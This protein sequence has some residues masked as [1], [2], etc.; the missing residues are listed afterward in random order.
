MT[1]TIK[2]QSFLRRHGIKIGLIT[3]LIVAGLYHVATRHISD[4]TPFDFARHSQPIIE[5][6]NT[7]HYWLTND[8]DASPEF[9]LKYRASSASL[10]SMGK[11]HIYVLEKDHQFIGFVAYHLE[12]INEGRILY[13]AVKEEFR[14]KRYGQQLLEFGVQQLRALGAQKIRLT[15]RTDNISGQ[16]LYN[17]AGFKEVG[18]DDTFVFFEYTK[19]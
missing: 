9:I 7:N 6:F 17:R 1:E 11:L 18:R 3:A 4:I 14:G 2:T 16:R 10:A 15:T 5:L 12:G 8:P 19:S 13:L